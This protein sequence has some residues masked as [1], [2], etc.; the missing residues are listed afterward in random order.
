M[1]KSAIFLDIF[2]FLRGSIRVYA[3]LFHR[4]EQFATLAQGVPTGARTILISIFLT[5]LSA[6]YIICLGGEFMKKMITISN[7]TNAKIKE[8]AVLNQVPQSQ[9]VEASVLLYL[10][11]LS[12]S[13]PDEARELIRKLKEGLFY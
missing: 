8:Y 10:A 6:G 3:F 12:D 7:S 9:M 4:S 2:R 1:L 11:Y 13:K 5:L